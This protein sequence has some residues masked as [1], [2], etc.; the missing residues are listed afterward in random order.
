MPHCNSKHLRKNCLHLIPHFSQHTIITY[1]STS[2]ITYHSTSIITYHNTPSS[3]IT[4]HHHHLPKYIHHHLSQHPI[5]TYHSTSIL[6]CPKTM[7]IKARLTH[8]ASHHSYQTILIV[9]IA[10]NTEH[11][12]MVICCV[13]KLL[14]KSQRQKLTI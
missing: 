13:H 8:K 4:A 3:L 1:H 12:S 7:Y 10:A 5:I 14:H 11:V 6:T 9:P 2:I